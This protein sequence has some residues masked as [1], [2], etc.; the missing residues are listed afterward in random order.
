MPADDTPARLRAAM[1]RR[2]VGQSELARRLGCAQPVVAKILAGKGGS[3]EWL[4]RAAVA[5]GVRPSE[6][7]PRLTGRRKA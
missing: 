3:L 4:H 5:L 6:L 1:D 2:G 7:D